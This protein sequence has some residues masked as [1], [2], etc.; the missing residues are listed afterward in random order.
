MS[1]M[2]WSG[3]ALLACCCALAQ[4]SAPPGAGPAASE[5]KTIVVPPLGFWGPHVP[6]PKIKNM[7]TLRIT[8]TRSACFGRCPAYTVEVRGDGTVRFSGLGG[9]RAPGDHDGHISQEAVAELLAAFRRADFFSL[10]DYLGLGRD[11]SVYT[12]SIEFDGRKKSEEHSGVP[13]LAPAVVTDLED[14]IDRLAGAGKWI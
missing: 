1:A 6:F 8:L 4:S 7:K 14:A 2:R 10:S 12:V 13:G 3:L 9:V 11:A 5:L